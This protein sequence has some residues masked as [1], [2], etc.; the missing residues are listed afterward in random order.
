MKLIVAVLLAGLA[1]GSAALAEPTKVLFVG[2]SY[3]FGRVDPVMSYN[4]ANVDRST[5]AI[6]PVSTNAS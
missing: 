5:S 1:L 3:T 6:A 2:N 4:T